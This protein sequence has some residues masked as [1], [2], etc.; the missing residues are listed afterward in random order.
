V[1]DWKVLP[2]RIAS[3][4]IF[5]ASPEVPTDELTRVLRSFT[6]LSLR[7]HLVTPANFE[8]LTQALL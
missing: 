2:Y 5:L 8:L 4:S 1:R 6:R 3:G 7:F